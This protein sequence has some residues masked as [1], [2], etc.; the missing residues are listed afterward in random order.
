MGQKP[1][2]TRWAQSHPKGYLIRLSFNMLGAM[3]DIAEGYVDDDSPRHKEQTMEALRNRKYIIGSGS[4]A[5]LTKLGETILP[6]A[7]EVMQPW[8]KKPGRKKV[9]TVKARAA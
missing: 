9:R 8:K 2:K 6:G 1:K 5:K 7:L 4:R 3:V